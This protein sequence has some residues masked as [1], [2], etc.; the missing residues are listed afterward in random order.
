MS[1]PQSADVDAGYE[2]ILSE[3]AIRNGYIAVDPRWAGF[4]ADMCGSKE[5]ADGRAVLFR[6][7]E[8][9]EVRSDLR[10]EG[11]GS[12]RIRS[13][14]TALFKR[15]RL[16]AGDALVIRRDGDAA[17]QVEVRDGQ[18][19]DH[20]E[21]GYARLKERLLLAMPGFTGFATDPRMQRELAYKRAL[22]EQFALLMA[23][24]LGTDDP[25][26]VWE[27]VLRLLKVRVAGDT[28]AAQNIVSWRITAQLAELSEADGRA[29]GQGVLALFASDPV[30][31]GVDAFNQVM[32]TLEA[33][34]QAASQRSLAS[35]L[36]TL[37]DPQ[38]YCFVKTAQLGRALTLLDPFFEWERG[39]ITAARW[40]ALRALLHRL[41][42]RLEADG[43]PV[44]DMLGLQSF[45]WVAI[46]YDEAAASDD[47]EPDEQEESGDD[48]QAEDESVR[49]MTV[50]PSNTLL[51]GPPGTGKTHAMVDRAIALLDPD[52]FGRTEGQ[53]ASGRSARKQRYD[54]LAAAGRI[55]F[56]TF[57]QSFAYEDF[58]EGLKAT[59]TDGG[60]LSYAVVPGVFLDL[61]R[62][63]QR[64]AQDSAPG[65]APP[66]LLIIDEINRGNIARIFG[67]LIT[68]I[69]PGKRQGMA[70]ALQ[71]RL[72]YSREP[73]AVP[74]NLHLLGTMNTADR[75]LAAMDIAL[76][77]RF[78]FV[79][80]PPRP[81]LLDR[82]VAGVHLGQLLDA[83]NQRIEVLL[84]RDHL[85]GHAYLIGVQDLAGLAEVFQ[86]RILPLLQEYFFEDWQRIGWVLNDLRKPDAD[87]FLGQKAIDCQQLFGADV[88]VP[89]D[90]QR[91]SIQQAAFDR[92]AA[93][94]GIIAVAAG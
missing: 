55:A 54:A 83:M 76:R 19:R 85:I 72:P 51:Y 6:L 45:L 59:T 87:R 3:G 37:H 13:R 36:L 73:F 42:E 84:G 71:V 58:V 4:S 31:A 33:P 43:W 11:P 56:V 27:S 74:A 24:A 53:G 82:Q 17:Y 12:A 48:D 52:L 70:E 92:V 47:G 29:M 30:D 46:S 8:G 67:E 16:Q 1:E 77:R 78:T 5:A 61:C 15:L 89:G 9:N 93:Y 38:H 64:A 65:Q 34:L 94:Q 86:N 7:P 44:D 35:L 79:E 39:G 91:W 88:A 32:S 2:V 21:A 20:F 28:P 80:M 75:S 68:L 40:G 22:V 25:A 57:H 81:D 62:Q 23:P 63:A 41:A 90:G 14:F 26:T 69:E 66:F 60:A 10:R 49:T 18:G 50:L